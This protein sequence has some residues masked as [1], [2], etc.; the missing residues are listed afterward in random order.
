MVTNKKVR[1]NIL[2]LSTRSQWRKWLQKNFEKETEAWLAFPN[3]ASGK[4]RILYND[5]VEE[6]LCFGWI[7]SVVNKLDT[8]HLIQRFTPRR[9]KSSYSQPNIERLRHLME[10]KK[11]HPSV[12]ESAKT[13]LKKKF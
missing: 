7:D 11:V 10:K 1:K 3:Q 2:H 6:A 4:K 12:I 13:I 9:N 5:A 8:D